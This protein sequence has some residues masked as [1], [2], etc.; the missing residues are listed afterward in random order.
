MRKKALKFRFRKPIGFKSTLTKET[1]RRKIESEVE[2]KRRIENNNV[3]TLRFY[4]GYFGQ[5]SCCP[6]VKKG[7]FGKTNFV[8]YNP[9]C[10]NSFPF[11]FCEMI[12]T[13]HIIF[14]MD[15]GD[16]N[17]VLSVLIS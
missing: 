14:R 10:L 6:N 11:F 5:K 17:L 2:E 12:A 13:Q 1:Q 3:Y 4:K 9:N 7:S 15:L 8:F 16:S